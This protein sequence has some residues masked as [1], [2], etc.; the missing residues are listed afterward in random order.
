MNEPKKPD[1]LVEEEEDR[2]RTYMMDEVMCNRDKEE[3]DSKEESE[4]DFQKFCDYSGNNRYP[5]E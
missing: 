3:D 5:T 1:W 4:S 2:K